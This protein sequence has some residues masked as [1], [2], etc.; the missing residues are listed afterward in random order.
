MKSNLLKA[1]TLFALAIMYLGS[2]TTA[3]AD[4]SNCTGVGDDRAI[5]MRRVTYLG[6]FNSIST[7]LRSDA[8]NPNNPVNNNVELKGWLYYPSGIVEGR[9]VVIFNHGHAKER[10]E[11]CTVAKYFVERGFVVFVPLR[12]GHNSATDPTFR[13]T[14][15]HID[16]FTNKCMREARNPNQSQYPI[17]PQLY[18]GSF[19]C[20]EGFNCSDPNAE[21]AFEV[22]YIRQQRDDVRD[23]IRFIKE[24]NGTF[25]PSKLADPN[26]IAVL[27]HSWGGS[28]AIFANE[29]DYGQNVVIDVSGAELSWSNQDPWWEFDLKDAMNAQKLPMYFLQPKNGLSLEPTKVLFGKAVNKEYRSQASIFPP[30]PWDPTKRD[31][32]GVLVTEARQAHETFIGRFNGTEMIDIWGPSVIEF[33]NRYPRIQL[34]E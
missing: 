32:D 25:Y 6:P 15:V 9:P 29:F 21:N 16:Y 8:E 5:R 22:G 20:R 12:R 26:R 31:E 27:G 1:A 33:I 11:P 3:R 2:A 23:Q 24:Q 30:A 18:C 28:L 4:I 7:D 13:S 19:Y 34:P 17:L 10:P 14:G